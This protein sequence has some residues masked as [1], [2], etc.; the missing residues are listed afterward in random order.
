MHIA[1]VSRA[2]AGLALVAVLVS[3]C[4]RPT[5]SPKAAGPPTRWPALMSDTTFVWSAEPGI[6][7][8]SG[9]AVVVRAYLESKIVASLG[10]SDDYLYPGF[11]R[12]VGPDPGPEFE[13]PPGTS[14]L[15]PELGFPL[16][17]P[18]AGSFQEHILRVVDG[19]RDVT[20]TVCDWGWGTAE[21]KA[22]GGPFRSWPNNPAAPG[23]SITRFKL[24]APVSPGSPL[25]VQ[26]GPSK[27]PVDDVFGDWR[28]VG[29]NS[30]IG[31]IG[32]GPEWP[33]FNQDLATCNA[34]A[35]ESAER[36]QFLTTGEHPRS[37]FPTLPT[38]PGWPVE[39]Q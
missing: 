34:L 23:I 16:T 8:L 31:P 21:S 13:P 35:P 27:F 5:P 10:G 29:V 7:L 3:A 6:D 26:Q 39:T 2:I 12:A 1:G 28:V 24:V 33:E 32:A 36:R 4:S 22:D 19:D 38:Y 11:A 18:R 20:V 15:W 14:A 30:A 25:P 9:P 17:G 37:D